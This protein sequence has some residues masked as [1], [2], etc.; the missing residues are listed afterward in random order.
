MKNKIIFAIIAVMTL[1]TG[2]AQNGYSLEERYPHLKKNYTIAVHPFY[3]FN[4]GMR[5]DL[6]KRIKHTPAWVQIG[7]IGHMLSRETGYYNHWALI[8]GDEVNYLLGGG[9]D[10]NY[11]RFLNKKESFYF[12][13]GCS[14]SHYN[15]EHT[16]KSL[17]SY[18]EDGLKYYTYDY[19]NLKKK[20][21]KLGL[22]A[23]IGYQS[24]RPTFLFDI[25]AGIGYR[26]SF[27]KDNDTESFNNSMV[28]LGYKGTVF[29]AGIRFGVKLR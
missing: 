18:T 29:V 1:S 2:A 12:A 14:Y 28:A 9:L 17:R 25:F 26:H 22:S 19:G 11:K 8:S 4:G 20:I 6:E 15:I 16:G 7:L 21:D 10:L 5:L 24:P 27:R 3:L 13:G 23:F